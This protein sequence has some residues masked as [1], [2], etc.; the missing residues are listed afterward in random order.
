MG[1]KHLT[2]QS[3]N[4][5]EAGYSGIH[6]KPSHR[7]LLHKKLGIPQGEKIPKSDLVDR[8]SDSSSLIKEKTFAS[9]FGK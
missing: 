7:G 5:H 4:Q 3:G 8:P 6:I 1:V 9:N 2:N